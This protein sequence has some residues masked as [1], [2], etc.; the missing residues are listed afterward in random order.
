MKRPDLMCSHTRLR[1]VPLPNQTASHSQ[2]LPSVFSLPGMPSLQVSH[3]AWFWG[4]ILWEVFLGPQG[5]RPLG[6]YTPWTSL[7]VSPNQA[8][9]GGQGPDPTYLCIPKALSLALRESSVRVQR[10]ELSLPRS[11]LEGMTESNMWIRGAKKPK[12]SWGQNAVQGLLGISA[13]WL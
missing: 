12:A 9:S 8:V 6:F 3:F 11:L 7:A 10:T 1:V 13:E 5:P 4:R 2:P